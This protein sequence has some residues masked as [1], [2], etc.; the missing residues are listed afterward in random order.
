MSWLMEPIYNT[1]SWVLLRWHE[2]W[3]FVL[4]GDGRFIGTNWEWVLAIVF[5]VVTVRIVLFPIFVKQIKSQ[6]AMQALA[7]KIRELQAKHKGDQQ[8]LREEMMKLYQTEK[9]NPLMGCL[10]MFLQIPVFFGLFHVLSYID[11]L[12]NAARNI[13]KT[14]YG[15]TPEL[16]DSAAAADLFTAPIPGTFAS[17]ADTLAAL[18]SP[19]GA[20]TKIVAAVLVL[21][22]MF[23]TFA[24]SRQMILK[25]GWQAEPQQRMIQRLMLYGIPISLMLSGW[26]F[27]IGV[28]IYWVTQNLISLGQQQ[29]VLRKYPPMIA[30][31]EPPKTARERAAAATKKEPNAIARFFLVLPPAAKPAGAAKRGLLAKLGLRKASAPAGPATPVEPATRSLAPRPGAKP[32]AVTAPLA[33]EAGTD[34][35]GAAEPAAGAKAVPAKQTPAKAVPA[36]QTP[37]KAAA[38]KAGGPAKAVAPAK[39]TPAKSTTAKTTTAA[40]NGGGT[41]VQVGR[42]PSVGK[43]STVG[44]SATPS[45]AQPSPAEVTD[46]PSANGGQPRS[47]GAAGGG[48][49]TGAARKA[50]PRRKGGQ[51]ARK[52]SGKR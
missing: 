9:V 27:P 11:P 37:A 39:S 20:A 52:G 38:G 49:R 41:E 46:A 43:T 22:M 29:W 10:P 21:I 36:K 35:S 32:R 19:G 7:P 6:R 45:P 17:G 13:P 44:R 48:G 42:L 3:A 30:A 34:T 47:G 40:A 23:T 26:Y 50:A 2:F 12:D 5:L 15:W 18:G 33:D 25:T 1:I 8:T 4:P 16:F 31:T 14:L 24:T 28:V 51:P